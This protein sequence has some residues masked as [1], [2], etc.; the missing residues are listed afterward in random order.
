MNQKV[1]MPEAL[2][3]T[4]R[5][6]VARSN[7]LLLIAFTA[8]NLILLT[9]GSGTYFLFSASVPYT[10]TD[11]AMFFC[12]MYPAEIYEG[13]G[14]EF[15]SPALFYV[16]IGFSVVLLGLYL[17]S[18]IFSKKQKV[19]WLI[20]ALV[21]FVLDTAW[22]FLYFGISGEL[23]MDILFHGWVIVSLSLGI[24]AHFK[25]KK[26][27]TEVNVPTI[28]GEEAA[29][30][31]ILDSKVLRYADN[32]VK[33]RIFLEND[34]YGHKIVY[35]RVK[36][37]N[38]LVIDGKVYGEYVAL[39]ERTHLLTAAVDGHTYGAGFDGRGFVYLTVDGMLIAQKAR[40]I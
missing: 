27:P 8:I 24:Y 23:I 32:D 5:Y 7:L 13:L 2:V 28:E 29:R 37:T 14:M 26:I 17:L 20:F 21:L 16:A 25:L 18:Y 40:T 9:T 12:G 39:L 38:E 31:D 35:R 4:N 1:S 22:M 34:I 19:G 10:F 6:N 33:A 11:L 36:K 3:Q 30:Q 15:L